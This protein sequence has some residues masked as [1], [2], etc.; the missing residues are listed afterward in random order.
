MGKPSDETNALLVIDG[1]NSLIRM[2]S[3][4][5]VDKKDDEIRIV[6]TA[7]S[8]SSV[9]SIHSIVEDIV[10]RERTRKYSNMSKRKRSDL[11][12]LSKVKNLEIKKWLVA[13]M[14][15]FVCVLF[16][17]THLAAIS[18]ECISAVGA[19]PSMMDLFKLVISKLLGD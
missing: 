14:S 6:A 17:V 2:S 18:D 8:K 4:D 16:L 13:I 10:K 19:P 11:E 7:L 3:A 1:V 5:Y 12:Y 15:I 9:D